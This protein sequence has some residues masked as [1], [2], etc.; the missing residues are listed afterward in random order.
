MELTSLP[1]RFQVKIEVAGCWNWIACTDKDGYG[2]VLWQGHPKRAHRVVYE[3]LVGLIGEGLTIDHLCEN[4]RCVNPDHM[5]PIPWRE[6]YARWSSAI[7]HCKSG[8]PFIQRKGGK[9]C[10]ICDARR[11]REYQARK[12]AT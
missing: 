5:E 9:V 12:K 11:Q 1:E 2:V 10:R 8:H 3:L 6:N 4:K 7:T